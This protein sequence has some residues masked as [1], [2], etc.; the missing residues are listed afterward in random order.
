MIDGSQSANEETESERKKVSRS[1]K[2]T[3]EK[4]FHHI[5]DFKRSKNWFD[6]VNNFPSKPNLGKVANE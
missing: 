4:T 6:S 5:S 3:K 2:R 1:G